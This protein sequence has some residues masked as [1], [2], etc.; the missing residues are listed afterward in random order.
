MRIDEVERILTQHTEH[1]K[2]TLPSTAFGAGDVADLVR[3]WL[4]GNLVV[5]GART[6]KS[7]DVIK[8]DGTVSMI[9]AKDR[10]V[11]GIEFG[12]V[13]SAGNPTSDGTPAL[14]IPLTLPREWTFAAAFPAI[15]N[16][17]LDGLGFVSGP[18]LH[19][20]SVARE[21]G[22]G[23][24][25][26]SKGVTFEAPKVKKTGLLHDFA[27]LLEAGGQ[28]T[29]SGQI[30]IGSGDMSDSKK[31]QP[32]FVLRS[33][34]S[35]AGSMGAKFRLEVVTELGP[36]IKHRVRVAA[37]VTIGTAAP[38]V[39]TA[40]LDTGAKTL[41]LTGT[42]TPRTQSTAVL[43]T[44]AGGSLAGTVTKNFKLGSAVSLQQLVIRLRSGKSPAEIVAEVSVQ[45]GLTTTWEVVE[46]HFTVRDIAA[47]F[48]IT[49]PFDGATRTITATARGKA[50]LVD[51]IELVADAV[52]FRDSAGV[53]ATFGLSTASPVDLVSLLTR[54]G[55][56][57]PDAPELTLRNLEITAVAPA[58]E[59]TLT[60]AVS[61]GW[62]LALGAVSVK[63]TQ[64]SVLLDYGGKK[65]TGE[66]S[67]EAELLPPSG[68][69]PLARFN[70]RWDIPGKFTLE[71]RLP[72][73]DLTALVRTFDKTLGYP[74]GLPAVELTAVVV[75]LTVAGNQ[76][77]NTRVGTEYVLGVSGTV[78]VDTSQVS[79]LALARKPGSGPT[80]FIAAVWTS[81]WTWY[82]DVLRWIEDCITVKAS[83][84]ALSTRDG[85]SLPADPKPPPN[86]PAKLGRG[87]TF[88]TT[89]EL[90]GVLGDA[91]KPVFG[92]AVDL[93][94]TGLL[95]KPLNRSELAIA[96]ANRVKD[97][98]SGIVGVRF[99]GIQ[100]RIVPKLAQFD[101]RAAFDLT[102]W[103]LNKQKVTLN[104]ALG[105]VVSL[106]GKLAV[107][108][109][110]AADQG[111]QWQKKLQGSTT[112]PTNTP[113]W[114]EPFGLKGVEVANFFGLI[115]VE[116][117]SAAV[118]LGAGGAL[119]LRSGK[120]AVQ[121]DL[122][123]V[124]GFRGEV[125]YLDAF[126]LVLAKGDEQKEIVLGD[127]IRQFT[128]QNS[129]LVKLT[130]EI[131]FRKFALAI[132][133]APNGFTDPRTNKHWPFGFRA[134]G[135]VTLFGYRL[136]F[137]VRIVPEQGIDAS[138]SVDK[139]IVLGDGVF[140]LSD[141]T[142]EKGP[143]GAVNTLV[144][145]R[146]G[147]HY[148]FLSGKLE[149]LGM[150][151]MIR[152][153]AKEGGW[154]FTW[155]AAAFIFTNSVSCLLKDG[156]FAAAVGGILSFR[157]KTTQPV[158]VGGIVIIPAGLDFWVRFEMTVAIAINPDFSFAVSG[159][160]K[161]G[162]Q[163]LTP[164]RFNLDALR[165][166]KKLEAA[167]VDY[168]AT[169]PGKIFHEFAASAEKWA[170]AVG[171]GLIKGLDDVA[172]I[173][174]EAFGVAASEAARLLK[175][176]GYTAEKAVEALHQIWNMTKDQVTKA[177][178][179]AWNLTAGEAR[180]IVDK[181]WELFK[182]CALERATKML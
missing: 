115:A 128:D 18:V 44:W 159:S 96:L 125:P 33:T 2:L 158:K 11:R 136:L 73:A 100:I 50:T 78:S 40:D 55:L 172:K 56:P 76:G 9:G 156:A 118:S 107:Y 131:K 27:A 182:S 67:A 139:P 138:G 175:L 7:G 169:Q 167:L 164:D 85:V 64:A 114:K 145:S 14:Y 99:T 105:G 68:K 141:S 41:V 75:R 162:S 116:P 97:G 153:T 15:K 6:K 38:I 92:G 181:V 121:L 150:S 130:D 154:E 34:W 132:V 23:A 148:V 79:F 95:A 101:L 163:T 146:V 88:F 3:R 122:A 1:D 45:L 80:E 62:Q 147:D 58:G 160:F 149:L 49:N 94:L 10:A 46:N 39:L 151:A 98:E 29:L 144:V 31:F 52:F 157:V 174:K 26:L 143:E 112:P 70:A 91:L 48:T 30:E 111:D 120:N 17:A 171:E 124:G 54:L 89:V 135:D 69:A 109:V 155:R 51:G 137:D 102:F 65:L 117:V 165:D 113:T 13:D 168:F 126:T 72:K 53:T 133:L 20:T 170:K 57:L 19:L 12:L 110:L 152:A 84:L 127:L 4:G 63:L 22:N 123:A 74:D 86:L 173:L 176:A 32:K 47:G 42:F 119:T 129:E 87:V 180:K 24:A 166:W 21:A 16:T 8:V 71:G 81:G 82:P 43:S 5:T 161:F 35:A 108:F 142:G 140:Q 90:K 37:E 179:A 61:S 106:K 134:A 59:F 178:Q 93:Q 66:I 28:V 77:L 177:L 60:A 103:D 25:A 104:L 83:G 36:P